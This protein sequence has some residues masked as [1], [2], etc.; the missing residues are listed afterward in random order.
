MKKKVTESVSAWS[1]AE[2]FSVRGGAIGDYTLFYGW[3]VNSVGASFQDSSEHRG[4]REL[5]MLVFSA[6]SEERETKETICERFVTLVFLVWIGSKDFYH[7]K[8]TIAFSQ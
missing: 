5:E 1:I 7:R 2:D 3:I 6:S 4:R 8:R